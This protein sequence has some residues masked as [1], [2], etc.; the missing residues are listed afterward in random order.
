MWRLV[1]TM[2]KSVFFTSFSANSDTQNSSDKQ[3]LYLFIQALQQ[4][5]TALDERETEGWASGT[6]EGYGD[7]ALMVLKIERERER[8]R[9]EGPG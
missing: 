9:A 8:G 7:H 1:E 5:G 4:V 6:N 3:H 2:Q